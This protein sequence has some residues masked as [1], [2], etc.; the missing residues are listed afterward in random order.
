MPGSKKAEY[1]IDE[2]LLETKLV[3]EYKY[4][5]A[6]NMRDQTHLRA[7]ARAVLDY[8]YLD[9][10]GWRLMGGDHLTNKLRNNFKLDPY[11]L[12]AETNDMFIDGCS[13]EQ[14]LTSNLR[15]TYYKDFLASAEGLKGE[16]IKGELVVDSKVTRALVD[17][18]CDRGRDLVDTI[19]DQLSGKQLYNLS[20]SPIFTKIWH[21][22][23]EEDGTS[24]K[25]SLKHVFIAKGSGFNGASRQALSLLGINLHR[26]DK[27]FAGE[28]DVEHL[29][30]DKH[31]DNDIKDNDLT[32]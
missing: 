21:Y 1:A 6:V 29:Y 10:Q 9:L 4:Y 23:F 27:V 5:Y 25:S 19:A 20:Y 15:L 13:K 26:L 3:K 7:I 18:Y 16:V 30:A 14:V 2:V 28:L 8:L 17:D 12:N 22:S 11:S 24:R 31:N 32:I